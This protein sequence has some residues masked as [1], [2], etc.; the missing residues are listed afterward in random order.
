[1]PQ[2]THTDVALSKSLKGDEKKRFTEL[3][4]QLKQFDSLKPQPACGTNRR[5]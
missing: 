2:V 4:A 5:G 1:M 3:A